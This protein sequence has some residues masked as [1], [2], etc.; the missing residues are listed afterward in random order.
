MMWLLNLLPGV[1]KVADA[2][3]SYFNKRL[4]TDLEKYKVDGR[5]DEVRLQAAMTVWGNLQSGPD[6]AM[7]WLFAYPLAAWWTLAIIN[8]SLR[9]LMGWTWEVHTFPILES[10]GWVIVGFLF[11]ASI[12]RRP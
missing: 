5:I 2:F 11:L 1:G 6:R 12:G 3:S 10:W 4:D 7:R 9:D 8:T